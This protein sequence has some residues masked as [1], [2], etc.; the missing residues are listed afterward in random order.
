MLRH[1]QD[2]GMCMIDCSTLRGTQVIESPISSLRGVE[3]ALLKINVTISD[4]DTGAAVQQAVDA[5]AAM[6]RAPDD[7]ID[8][9]P[10]DLSGV[11]AAA[12]KQFDLGSIL[13]RLE[14][15][16]ELAGVAAE[17]HPIVKL[18]WGVVSVAYSVVKLQSD[19]DILIQK[20]VGEMDESCKVAQDAAPLR[21]RS[22]L[23]LPKSGLGPVL[24]HTAQ[25]RT[26]S[27]PYIRVN[28][29]DRTRTR[30]KL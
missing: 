27:S 29:K 13:R 26:T 7:P 12:T 21:D 4:L 30:T 8:Q 14:G 3:I 6:G 19:R 18:A 9:V 20:L 11:A 23:G 5:S 22:Q 1:G 2:I 24:T 15:F 25:D 10:P 16:M 17:I 28:V